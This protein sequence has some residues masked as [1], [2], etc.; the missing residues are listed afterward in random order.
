[1]QTRPR[2]LSSTLR[3]K[4]HSSYLGESRLVSG[5]ESIGGRSVPHDLKAAP[6]HW[7]TRW[8]LNMK[9]D[10]NERTPVSV[11]GFRK[12]NQ[13]FLAPFSVLPFTGKKPVLT[14]TEHL[15][16]E[17]GLNRNRFWMTKLILNP[18][19]GG[20]RMVW[21]SVGDGSGS[22][23]TEK[24]CSLCFTSTLVLERTSKSFIRLH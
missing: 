20:R 18:V 21:R 1:M 6:L 13:G 9:F 7:V 11:S 19:R 2:N 8:S 17:N 5:K 24:N 15:Y 12:L 23:G 3:V 10:S 22:S 16:R 14:T 4:G